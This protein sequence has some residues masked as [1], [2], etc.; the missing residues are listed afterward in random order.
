MENPKIL[1]S[2]K[3]YG[4]KNTKR[5]HMPGHK[6]NKE[7]VKN[8]KS[9]ENDITEL[10][11]SDSLNYPKGIILQAEKQVSKILKAQKSYFLTDGSTCGVLTMLYAVKDLGKSIIVNRNAHQSV[12]NGCHLAGLSPITVDG[13]YVDG[14][15]SLPT[16]E[17]VLEAVDNCQDSIGVLLTY[18]DYYGRTFDIITLK[19]E[20]KKRNKLLLIDG[21][22]GAHLRFDKEVVYH[23]DYADIYVD[24]VHKTLPS[25]TQSAIL[26]V[27]NV[28][29][30]EK[31]ND[32]INIFRTSSPSYLIS[33]SI[34]YG[35]YFMADK[36]ENLISAIKKR[37]D[38]LKSELSIFGVKFLDTTDKLK[39]ALDTL[40][41]NANANLFEE[42][43]EKNNVY[44][45]L[46]DSRYILFY[47]S[48]LTSVKE[49]DYLQKIIIKFIKN[50]EKGNLIISDKKTC[51]P[52]RAMP[53]SQ[54]INSP[55]ELIKIE[56]AKGRICASNFG[57]FP[58]CY[59]LCL[60]GEII[61]DIVIEKASGNSKL[62]GVTDG[63]IK[64]VK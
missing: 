23:G 22:H 8:F 52:S 32:T 9:A 29:L 54:A 47:L 41:I 35:E 62:F 51:L 60:A 17:S 4:K 11:F 63:K 27:N 16:V 55:Y 30:I 49:L 15:L 18:P 31:V 43:L 44:S 20:L 61:D 46:N 34:E 57:E 39:L 12:Y 33:S 13:E 2:L 45:E 6:A 40:S 5:F 50:A 19:S 7:F 37:I 36:G 26:S 56:D 58:P 59:P 64:V 10:S 38:K 1:T 25:L 3:I 21:A 42:Y 48:P 24:G 14:V 53:Y 28:D